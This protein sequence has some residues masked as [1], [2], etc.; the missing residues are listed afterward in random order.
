LKALTLSYR[1]LLHIAGVDETLG[2]IIELMAKGT[3]RLTI[4]DKSLHLKGSIS[5]INVLRYLI[6]H[7]SSYINS[8]LNVSA[9]ELMEPIVTLDYRADVKE[10]IEKIV[11]SN[12]G[13][14]V[15]IDSDSVVRGVITE[16]CII[17]RL[18][19]DSKYH[20]K[21]AEIA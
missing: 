16:E 12:S 4:V 18:T 3:C 9:K 14:I 21:S 5:A 20:L 8:L 1:D 2:N 11:N 7:G 10:L 6:R 13:H 15:L 19:I 17:R